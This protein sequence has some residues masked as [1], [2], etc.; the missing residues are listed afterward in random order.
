MT[1]SPEQAEGSARR[2]GLF[3]GSFDPVHAGHLHAARAA[4]AAFDLDRVVFVPARE[5]PH[6]PGRRLAAGEDR[7]EMLRLATRDEPR[8][9]VHGLELSRSGPSYTID[10]VRALPAALGE[11]ED[12]P[13]YLILGGDNLE[14]LAEWREAGALLDRVQPVVVHRAGEPAGKFEAPER[15][16]EEIERRLGRAAADKVR[17]G[18]LRLP[19]VPV[20]SSDLR[21]RLPGLGPGVLDLPPA[22]FDYI[23]ARGLYGAAR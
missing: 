14:G 17:A 13:I 9:L 12:V 19:P 11:A 8:F 18:Y 1:P 2:L 20:S 7:L 5:P 15:G 16:L 21:A 10:T 22:V 23:R 4:L 3:G 6:K